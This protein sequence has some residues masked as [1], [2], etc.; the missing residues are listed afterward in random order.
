M[1]SHPYL[2]KFKAKKND[3]LKVPHE[4][5]GKLLCEVYYTVF[6]FEF[7][8][9]YTKLAKFAIK[10]YTRKRKINSAEKL[11]SSEN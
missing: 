6:S 8:R 1:F 10:A 3:V 11:T 5:F 9:N 4:W 2:G 7:S